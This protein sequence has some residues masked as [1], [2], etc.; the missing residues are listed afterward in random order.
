MLT[1]ASAPARL[2]LC[3]F[4]GLIFS[5]MVS[6]AP[7]EL[8]GDTDTAAAFAVVFSFWLL[9]HK[10][11]SR[12]PPVSTLLCVNVTLSLLLVVA[13]QSLSIYALAK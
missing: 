7:A 13:G 12:S 6:A 11:D 4:P 10:I 9:C 3:L 1:P 8:V 5:D 2:G